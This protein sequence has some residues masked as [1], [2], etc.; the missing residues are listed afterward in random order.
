MMQSAKHPSNYFF[1]IFTHNQAEQIKKRSNFCPNFIR[2][3]SDLNTAQSMSRLN[4]FITHCLVTVN[5]C[6]CIIGIPTCIS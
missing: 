4:N 5:Y 3:T 1:P 2:N 6:R